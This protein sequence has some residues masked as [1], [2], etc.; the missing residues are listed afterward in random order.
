MPDD[1]GPSDSEEFWRFSLAFYAYPD[2]AEALI[3]LQDREALDVNLIL[4]GLWLGLS[5]RGR[6]TDAGL[7]VAEAVVSKIRREITEPLRLIRRRLRGNPDPSVQGLR[8][9]IKEIELEGERLAQCRLGRLA[10]GRE[11]EIPG[12]AR[13]ATALANLEFYLGS[14]RAP[15]LEAEKIRKAV[16]AFARG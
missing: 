1:D 7:A 5:G 10:G 12:A 9:R 11:N 16:R 4:F 14:E 2:T 3:V 13:Q 6:L 15:S 8:E